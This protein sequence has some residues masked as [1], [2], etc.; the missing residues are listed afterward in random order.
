[1]VGV[2]G[3]FVAIRLV[4]APQLRTCLV[5]L[6]LQ[7]HLVPEMPELLVVVDAVGEREENAISPHPMLNRDHQA[8]TGPL[9]RMDLQASSSLSGHLLHKQK[10][11]FAGGLFAPLYIIRVIRHDKFVGACRKELLS[12]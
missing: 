1:M 5:P 12:Y 10:A 6:L 4:F 7:G 9:A 8:V 2:S 3:S 11:S